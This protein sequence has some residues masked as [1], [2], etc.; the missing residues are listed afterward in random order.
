MNQTVELV[1]SDGEVKTVLVKA[2]AAG[3][4]VIFDAIRFTVQE[5]TFEL[6]SGGCVTDDDLAYRASGE[7]M[8]IFGFGVTARL[9]K[10]RDFYDCAWAIGDGWGHIAFGGKRQRGSVLVSIM[11]QG[12]LA[13]QE[14]WERR[15]YDWLKETAVFPK[16]T[17][18]DLAH[19]YFDGERR[20]EEFQP[21]WEAGGFD[22]WYNRP[23]F[24]VVGPWLT[25]DKW[26]KGRSIYV[27]TRSAS[28]LFRAY[29][30]GKQLGGY[31]SPWLRLEAE[32]AARGVVIPLEI[33]IEPTKYFVGLYPI[34]QEWFAGDARNLVTVK[35]AQAAQET[36][37]AQMIHTERWARNHYG[38]KLAVLRQLKGDE[39]LLDA[40]CAEEVDPGV[41]KVPNRAFSP[42]PIGPGKVLPLSRVLW[43]VYGIPPDESDESADTFICR[44]ALTLDDLESGRAAS[45]VFATAAH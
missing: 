14:G 21:I 26:G 43:M 28:V 42:D 30:K 18:A 4:V 13:A 11:G 37:E 15:L 41:Y 10:G 24:E 23:E 7:L 27:G 17:R 35:K 33:L 5:R 8:K 25:G 9:E 12:L 36:V 1:L 19:D 16:I 3:E 6:L 32:L 40:I 31:Q 38:K 29:E 20:I 22:R 44:E 45:P 39:A 2:P 34:L